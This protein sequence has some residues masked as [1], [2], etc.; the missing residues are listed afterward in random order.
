MIFYND[1]D[2]CIIASIISRRGKKGGEWE[3]YW[4]VKNLRTDTEIGVNLD[5]VE[6]IKED[7]FAQETNFLADQITWETMVQN[8]ELNKSAE[9]LKA[10]ENEVE[11]WKKFNV[12]EEV[13]RSSNIMQMGE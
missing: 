13:N 6:W 10:K 1:E 9:Y 7:A 3:N 12:Y 5:E 8:Y 4:N 11:K 2:D